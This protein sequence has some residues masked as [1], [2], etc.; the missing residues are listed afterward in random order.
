[1]RKIALAVAMAL[2]MGAAEV[3]TAET[4][5][6]PAG[7]MVVDLPAG[8]RTQS[9]GAPGQTA[10]LAFNPANDCYFFGVDNPG[11][12]NASPGAVRNTTT[13]LAPESWVTAA[14]GLR[15]FFDAAPS[16][17]SQTVDTSGFWPVQRAEFAGGSRPVYGSVQLRPGLEL[18]A[19]CSG[20]GGLA[21]FDQIFASMRH[22]ND[23]T[24]RS[25]AERQASD[26]A[27]AAQQTQQPQQPQE[28]P[29]E[30]NRRRRNNDN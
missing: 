19:F 18:R 27:A 6:D 3:A 23:A 9:R 12:A 5:T 7:R 2:G 24:W 29:Q 26:R 20:A 25:A 21:V 28:Q 22:S 10:I 14:S 4:W 13:P 16:L 1:M 15:D 30:N 17:T 8:W 11:T